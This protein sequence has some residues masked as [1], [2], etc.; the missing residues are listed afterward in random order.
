MIAGTHSGC[1]KTTVTLGLLAA[2]RRQGLN[3]QPFK[4]GPDYIDT[5][6]H[7]MASGRASRNLDL[8]ICGQ[9]YVQDCFM[10][11]SAGADISIVEG[12]M[13]LHDGKESSAALAA[14]LGI[15]VVLVV[16]GYG[17]AESA[18]A[19]VEGFRT[20][21][22]APAR[23][24]GVILN[25]VASL[26]HLRRLSDGIRGIPVFGYL[27]RDLGFEIPH[28]HLGLV[29]AEEEPLA[30]AGLERLS[31]C[32][33]EHVNL[34]GLLDAAVLPLPGDPE[35][36]RQAP[37]KPSCRIGV[38]YDR[39]FSFYY[40]D[41][42]DLLRD[43]GAEIVRF[44]PLSD[45]AIPA[46]VDAVYLGGGYP[47]LFAEQLSGNR[48]MLASMRDWSESSR[49]LYAECGGKMYLSQGIF[50]LEERFFPMAGV[51]GFR[52]RMQKGRSRI[53]Y[54]EVVLKHDSMLGRKGDSLRGHE[55]HYSTVHEEDQQGSDGLQYHVRDRS[56]LTLPDEGYR[57]R[58]TLASYIHLHFGS[59]PDAAGRFVR[60]AGQE[61]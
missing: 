23:I 61:R 47:E 12:V 36:R 56:G 8:W 3:V 54:R 27:P 59:R 25:R 45:P 33:L 37:G 46:G 28:R 24:I 40:E 34:P 19:V 55:F 6:L 9:G 51:F 1:G 22:G 29:T 31:D 58:N 17:M 57:V 10:R 18:G 53:G 4:A 43:A 39:A 20:Y 60:F 32:V 2:L 7:S 5:G 26:N 16:D 44:S 11:H 52:T 30:G 49:P 41:N 35:P 38:A 21:G 13:G 42:F 15:P 48:S 14:G 50:D